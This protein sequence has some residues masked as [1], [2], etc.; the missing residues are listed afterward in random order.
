MKQFAAEIV[1][2]LAYLRENGII[3]RDLK[4]ENIILDKNYHLKLIDFG[5]CKVENQRLQEK[6]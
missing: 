6:I 4:P 1:V 3:H 5:S 2:A